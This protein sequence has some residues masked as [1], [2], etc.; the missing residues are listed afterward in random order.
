MATIL[1]N[2]MFR[3]KVRIYV[4]MNDDIYGDADWQLKYE[5]KASVQENRE[6]SRISSSVANSDYVAYC[7]MTDMQVD[8]NSK[9]DWE[10]FSK[11]FTDDWNAW[12]DVDK[13]SFNYER[14]G[15]VIYFNHVGN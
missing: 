2:D 3:D 11:K 13:D 12:S 6:L 8:M 5:T 15:T 10:S 7:K 14:F 1:S 9:L 4:N